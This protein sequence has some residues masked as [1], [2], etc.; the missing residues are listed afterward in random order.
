MTKWLM[1]LLSTYLHGGFEGMFLSCDVLFQSEPSPYSFLNI[2]ERLLEAG[3]KYEVEAP[4]NEPE[5][6]TS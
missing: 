4:V 1:C 3:K 5:V 6:K 2:K